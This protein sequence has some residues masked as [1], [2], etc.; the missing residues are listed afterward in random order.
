MPAAEQVLALGLVEPDGIIVLFMDKRTLAP[1]RLEVP[2]ET[3]DNIKNAINIFKRNYGDTQ[4]C[5]YQAV[6][7]E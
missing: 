1:D 2:S 4:V 7:Q 6:K 5:L 3:E